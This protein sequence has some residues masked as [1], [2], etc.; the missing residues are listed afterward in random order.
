MKKEVLRISNATLEEGGITFLNNLNMYI[1]QGE[2]VGLIAR[3]YLGIFELIKLICQNTPL[4]YGKVYLNEDL[5]NTYIYRKKGDNNVFLIDQNSRLIKELTVSENV[6]VVRKGY[7]KYVVNIK[8]LSKQLEGILKELNLSIDPKS[9]V[10]N[11]TTLELYIIELIKAEATGVNLVIIR[12]ISEKLTVSELNKFHDIMKF[13]ANRGIAFLYLANHQD[14]IFNVCDRVVLY[15]DGKIVKNLNKEDMNDEYIKLFLKQIKRNSVFNG[16]KDDKIIQYIDICSN[17]IKNFNLDIIKGECLSLL[18]CS[19]SF[20]D[21]FIN[22]TN[23]NLKL[24]DGKILYNNLGKNVKKYINNS[25]SVIPEL[26]ILNGLFH[27][28]S[29]ME[30]LCFLVDKKIKKSIVSK[31]YYDS[32][33]IE[34]KEELG[35]DIDENK[36]DKLSATSLY[37]IVYYRVLIL[38]PEIVF[39]INPFSGADMYLRIH[40]AKLIIKLKKEGITIV[41]LTNQITDVLSV[42]DRSKWIKAEK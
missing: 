28:M 8:K 20:I 6:F 27:Q 7:K 40:I 1:T 9:A 25:I 19:P 23:G 26:P 18:G 31:K 38:K 4:K 39:I 14:E 37:N 32:I 29:Y 2:I 42:S 15:D 16:Q 12:N 22:I 17:N 33:K 30:N 11:L 41:L 5:V 36:I 10:G 13:F 34:F 21:E 3:S 35:T 24:K